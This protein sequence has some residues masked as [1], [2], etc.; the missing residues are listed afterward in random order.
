M[1]A[2]AAAAASAASKTAATRTT[3]L[4]LMFPEDLVKSIDKTQKRMLRA[5][6]LASANMDDEDVDDE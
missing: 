4:D 5:A 6:L 1:P 2:A 3:P